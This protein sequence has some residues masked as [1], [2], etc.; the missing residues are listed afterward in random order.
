MQ[1]EKDVTGFGRYLQA[2]RL[3]K[4]IA[5]EKVS[6]ETRIGLSFLRAIEQESLSEL[7]AEV[8]LKGFLRSYSNFIGADGNEVIRRFESQSEVTRAIEKFEQMPD[9]RGSRSV[10]KLFIALA[11]LGLLIVIGVYGMSFF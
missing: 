10:L 3:E 8:F 6:Q 7:P 5:L 4:G 9:R 11:F 1:T 2:I